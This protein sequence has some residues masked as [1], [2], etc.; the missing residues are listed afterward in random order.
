MRDSESTMN[1]YREK[2]HFLATAD[3][4]GKKTKQNDVV[5]PN[6]SLKMKLLHKVKC[7]II[8]TLHSGP[9]NKIL[10]WASLL[11]TEMTVDREMIFIAKTLSGN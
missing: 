1:T 4:R 5:I 8:S 2:K 6:D 7:H 10:A 3:V 11:C 9:L